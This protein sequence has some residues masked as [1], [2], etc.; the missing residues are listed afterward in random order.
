MVVGNKYEMRS[1]IAQGAW[2]RC[3]LVFN[4]RKDYS[5]IYTGTVD[6]GGGLTY[7]TSTDIFYD[8]D[9]ME[10]AIYQGSQDLKAFLN[11]HEA[12]CPDFVAA[13]FVRPYTGE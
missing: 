10:P 1:D 3:G 5:F 6:A 13:Q 7:I 2:L 11:G 9:V 4:D 8:P 12:V